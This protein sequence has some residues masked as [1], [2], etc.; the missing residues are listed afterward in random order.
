MYHRSLWTGGLEHDL[1]IPLVSFFLYRRELLILPLPDRSITGIELHTL[2]FHASLVL[3][4]SPLEEFLQLFKV[5]LGP[6]P[7]LLILIF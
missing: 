4:I 6:F 3:L 5:F 2:I 1:N 7:L